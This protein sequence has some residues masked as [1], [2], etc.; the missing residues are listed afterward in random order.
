MADSTT[1]PP[2][3]PDKAA[4]SENK[5]PDGKAPE[6]F[7]WSLDRQP[8]IPGMATW[9][10]D[11]VEGVCRYSPEWYNML[12]AEPPGQSVPNNWTWWSGHMHMDD[13]PAIRAS[14]QKILSGIADAG[15]VVFRM[16][17]ADGRWI[18]LLSRG[19]VTAWREDGAPAVMSGVVIDISHFAVDPPL[20]TP[21][22]APFGG[23]TGGTG[24][25]GTAALADPCASDDSRLLAER[26][27]LNEQRLSALYHLTLMETYP[28]SEVLHFALTSMLQLTGSGSGF[29]FLPDSDPLGNGRLF[30]SR[31]SYTHADHGRLPLTVLPR[32]LV[33]APPGMH[34]L[35][36][37][38]VIVNGDGET[39]CLTLFN[40]SM[41]IMRYVIAPAL[42]GEHVVCVA[43]VC[44]KDTDYDESD[45]QQVETFI[46]AA[47]LLLR[48]RRHLQ[49]L[50]DAKDTAETANKAKD[51]FIA[52]IS[53]EL[54][55]PLN[56]VLS[57]LQI[58]Q[59]AIMEEE[60]KELLDAAAASGRMLL[61]IISDILDFSHMES[62]KMRLVMESFSFKASMLSCLRAF[63]IEAGMKGL[64]FSVSVDPDI[65]E[66]LL[67]D[68][69]R[70][71]QIVSNLVGNALKFTERG[72][73]TLNC[74]LP[75]PQPPE[76]ALIRIA[77]SDTGIGIPADKQRIIFDAFTQV[78]SSNTKKHRG[79]GLGLSIV[80]HLIAMM[81]GELSLASTEGEGTTV[82]CSLLCP[83]ADIAAEEPP[84]DAAATGAA[85][86]RS[87]NILVAEDDAV[88]RLAINAFLKRA[89]H[90]PLCV[91]NGPQAL[92]ALQIFPFHCLFTDIQ[93]PGMDGL[94]LAEHIQKGTAAAFPPSPEIRAL[95]RET[96]PEAPESP[97]SIDP[98]LIIAAVSAHSLAGDRDRFLSHGIHYYLAKP[99]DTNQLHEILKAI[100]RKLG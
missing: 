25:C 43:G 66:V 97:V 47:W 15:E 53:H 49:E 23:D 24:Q 21:E 38:R 10:W 37:C 78:D 75:R 98:A 31:D 36:G 87:M 62:G 48:R 4:S 72:S 85:P 12:G 92:E 94:E 100:A 93:M 61:H 29:I 27:R 20:D 45:L 60:H 89:G 95:V 22:P 39:P 51:L 13:M 86:E 35:A 58:L 46:N 99:I 67:G 6:P 68:E 79:T 71:R 82:T 59:D 57:M 63:H 44:N 11:L 65:P 18:R 88:G 54:R 40:Q 3:E 52:N 7:R 96:Y 91:A 28:E 26:A 80:K 33:E 70:I 64:S 56:G 14:Q 19:L 5:A 73:I 90:R 34:P 50:R 76:G 17:R 84:P 77:I 55:T 8:R 1:A 32:E 16:R 74:S 30:W 2:Q 81:H 9:E 41:P 42:E 69:G 83:H